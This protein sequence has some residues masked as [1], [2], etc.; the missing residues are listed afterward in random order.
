VVIDGFLHGLTYV[1]IDV[2]RL[3]RRF[4]E[5]VVDGLVNVVGDGIFGIGRSLRV[6]QTGNLR[7]YV[8]FIAIGLVALFMLLLMFFPQ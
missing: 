2:S 8:M 1:T 6:V 7:Q 4:D 3:D 5:G